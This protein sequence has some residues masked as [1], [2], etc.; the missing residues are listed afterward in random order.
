MRSKADR[1]EAPPYP[2]VIPIFRNSVAFAFDIL[3][4]IKSISRN[5]ENMPV[6]LYFF[7]QTIYLISGAQNI[8]DIFSKSRDLST[9]PLLLNI[10]DTA[11]GL[12][13][14]D[15]RIFESDNSEMYHKPSSGSH[16]APEMRLFH[17]SHRL[18]SQELTGRSLAELSR[19]FIRIF[20]MRLAKKSD[21]I[22]NDWAEIPDIFGFI[23]DEAFIAT[24]VALC[25]DNALTLSP[26]FAKEF[27]LF[28]SWVP[29]LV[30]EI[31]RW[32]IPKGFSARENILQS[33]MKWH[34]FA[35]KHFD[36]AGE[37]SDDVLWEPVYGHKLMRERAKM[38][39]PTGLSAKGRA[40]NDLGM[41]WGA[42]ANIVPSASW[43]LI[44]ILSDR[45]LTK[46]VRGEIAQ[47]FLTE[48]LG[49]VDVTKLNSC[50][51]LQSIISEV[52]RLNMAIFIN[53]TP[54]AQDFTFGK[55]GPAK[56]DAAA[57]LSSIDGNPIIHN[58]KEAKF[59]LD[60]LKG[61]YIPFGG[62]VNMC[63]GRQYAKNEM[64][65]AVAMLLWAFDIEFWDLEGVKKTGQSLSAFGVGTLTPDRENAIRLRKRKL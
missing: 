22:G 9:K 40:A 17:N 35:D 10:L 23:R 27:W 39:K 60:G 31:P 37:I 59:T 52:L 21:E 46:R 26:D 11:F 2:Y 32:F 44:Y 63:P 24:T 30:M 57:E 16:V 42:N 29:A 45:E 55:C 38:Y 61:V 64:A 41:I 7:T 43:Y 49:S 65:L 5:Y 8:R 33:I 25:G 48:Y 6:R 1:I 13:P 56:K 36:S 34:E 28:D 12:P 62:G 3:G 51:I 18:F 54:V 15:A 47:A 58:D 14:S 53:W 19:Q 4:T 20:A 50:P